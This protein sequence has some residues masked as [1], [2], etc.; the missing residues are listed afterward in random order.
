LFKTETVGKT[1]SMECIHQT[2]EQNLNIFIAA[3]EKQNDQK[4]V[5][6]FSEL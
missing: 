2:K 6:F 1:I 3:P 4:L 5:K